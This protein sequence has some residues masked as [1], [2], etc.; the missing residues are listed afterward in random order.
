[1]FLDIELGKFMLYRENVR[2]VDLQVFLTKVFQEQDL[3]QK[4]YGI[5]IEA[6]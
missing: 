1:M 2:F 4:V 3:P 6:V 5:I